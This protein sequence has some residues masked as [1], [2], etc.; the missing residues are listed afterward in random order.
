M[1]SIP[2]EKIYQYKIALELKLRR[3]SGD[4]FQDFFAKV[5]SEVHGDDY[6]PVRSYGRL[7]DKGCDG[8]LQSN[9]QVFQCYGALNS[10]ENKVDYLTGKMETDFNKA[11]GNLS[12]IMK[13]WTMAHNLFGAPVELVLKMGELQKNDPSYSYSFFS[14]KSFEEK[15]FSLP[16]HVVDEILGPVYTTQD[17]HN[18]QIEELADVLDGVSKLIL[19]GSVATKEIMPVPVDK[20]SFN[21]LGIEWQNFIKSGWLNAF[22]VEEYFNKHFDPLFGDKISVIF[23]TAYQGLKIEDLSPDKIMFEL[24]SMVVGPY[25]PSP[26]RQV[27]SGALLAY[28]FEGCQIFED[29]PV[30][31]VA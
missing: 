28:L 12:S 19:T 11:K 30:G 26:T 15:L 20:L 1:N 31:V 6:V 21:N 10:N 27:T 2:P 22:L 29:K 14:I 9:G 8:Y 4:E 3:S 16:E 17:L 23:K 7:G 13:G 5:M 25:T 18:M 24:Y